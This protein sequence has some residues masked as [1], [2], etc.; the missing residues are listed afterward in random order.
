MNRASSSAPGPS[1]A[2]LFAVHIVIGCGLLAI[3]TVLRMRGGMVFLLA[4]LWFAGVGIGLALRK[5]WAWWSAVIGH[6]L[7]VL[8]EAATLLVSAFGARQGWRSEGFGKLGAIVLAFVFLGALVAALVSIGTWISL[9][10]PAVRA[11]FFG[12]SPDA[13]SRS[14]PVG[15]AAAVGIFVL[16]ALA[17]VV[18]RRESRVPRPPGARAAPE[19]VRAGQ[20]PEPVCASRFLSATELLFTPDSSRFVGTTGRGA[21]LWDARTGTTVATIESESRSSIAEIAVSPDGRLLALLEVKPRQPGRVAFWDLPAGRETSAIAIPSPS[22]AQKPFFAFGPTSA[23]LFVQTRNGAAETISVLDTAT[24]GTRGSFTAAGGEH[25]RPVSLSPDRRRIAYAADG[26]GPVTVADVESGRHVSFSPS[27]SA[28]M[29]PRPVRAGAATAN[30]GPTASESARLESLLFSQDGT[31]LYVG[32]FRSVAVLDVASGRERP[33]LELPAGSRMGELVPLSVSA[34]GS[35]LLTRMGGYLFPIFDLIGGSLV[36]L[37]AP[38]T[39]RSADPAPLFLEGRLGHFGGWGRMVGADGHP[40]SVALGPRENTDAGAPGDRVGS[41]SAWTSFVSP[42]GSLLVLEL[43][44]LSNL[45]L[46]NASTGAW[47][48]LL[49]PP[50]SYGPMVQAAFSPDG[51]RLAVAP[52]ARGIDVWDVPARKLLYRIGGR[53][54][55]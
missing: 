23:T 39:S 17:F 47:V 25:I 26:R 2:L 32:M 9:V 13:L 44:A 14:A 27:P 11:A 31:T 7:F 34:D 36:T 5:P 43:D 29:A 24:G 18:W 10:R 4:G 48:D 6:P 55:D 28:A 50:G 16:G 30:P 38:H 53:D 41:T 1:L 33:A 3:G 52:G 8:V 15:L 42:D 21:C 37:G 20:P 22:T 19:R 51:R 46:W 49:S 45:T 12:T 54:R 40:I 35:R